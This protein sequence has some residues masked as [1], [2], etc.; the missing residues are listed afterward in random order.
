MEKTV[1]WILHT[2]L[3]VSCFCYGK[4][5]LLAYSKKKKKLTSY[6]TCEYLKSI[7]RLVVHWCWYM[8]ENVMPWNLRCCHFTS[9]SPWHLARHTCND[10]LCMW[11]IRRAG[12]QQPLSVAVEL[13]GCPPLAKTPSLHLFTAGKDEL[14]RACWLIREFGRLWTNLAS[15]TNMPGS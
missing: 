7:R 5:S 12:L 15:V 9:P 4:V 13:A 2:V 10:E 3:T 1:N 14:S 8:N 11:S 6:T